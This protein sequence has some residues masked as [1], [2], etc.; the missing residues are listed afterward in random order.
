VKRSGEQWRLRDHVAFFSYRWMAWIVAAL[1]LTIPN[2]GGGSLPRDAGLLL[3]IGVITVIATALAQSYVR[4]LRQRPALL[5]LDLAACAA[6][7]WL[8][9]SGVLPFLPYA[10]GALVLPAL[11]F[12]WRGALL[13]AASF[14][15]LDSFG[16]TVINPGAGA[17]LEPSAI[18][19]RLLTPFAFAGAWALLG[20]LLKREAGS[21]A[22]DSARPAEPTPGVGQGEPF[23]GRTAPPLRVTNL[24]RP[25]L[26]PGL[27]ASLT[28]TASLL[29]ARRLRLRLGTGPRD[30]Q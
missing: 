22:E 5:A 15:A 24:P 8:S 21:G 3:L 19:V 10:L 2:L 26:P 12:S 16:L 17:A 11:A 9:D 18:M 25:E 20:R 30:Q 4:L 23:G 7:L 14:T 29:I 1:A 28:T 6:I 27:P 13:A